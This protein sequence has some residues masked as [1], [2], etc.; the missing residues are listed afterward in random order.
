[1]FIVLLWAGLL[2]SPVC[3]I[4]GVIGFF[5][6]RR[7]GYRWFAGFSIFLGLVLGVLAF[8]TYL[9]FVASSPNGGATIGLGSS[10]GPHGSNCRRHNRMACGHS[11]VPRE[12][13]PQVT[14][15]VGSARRGAA[16]L[17]R[18]RPRVPS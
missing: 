17:R 15:L 5:V 18:G 6:L 14:E 12:L 7:K 1:M 9:Y 11:R 16:R 13:E 4:L 8:Y 3:L 2:V 10:A